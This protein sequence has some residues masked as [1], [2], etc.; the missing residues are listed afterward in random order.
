MSQGEPYETDGIE[1]TDSLRPDRELPRGPLTDEGRLIL[2]ALAREIATFEKGSLISSE[3]PSL[4]VSL[5]WECEKGHRW[6]RSLK[7]VRGKR[8]WCPVCRAN[9]VAP[10]QLEELARLKAHAKNRGGRCISESYLGSKIPLKWVCEKGH[11]FSDHANKIWNRARGNAFCPECGKKRRGNRTD[12]NLGH[13]Q[14]FAASQGGRC[15]ASEYQNARQEVEWEC[16]NKHRFWKSTNR[17]LH[18]KDWCAICGGNAPVDIEWFREYAIERGGI[19]LSDSLENI[20]SIIQ[21]RCARNHEWR[22]TAASVRHFKTW[23][24]R[25]APNAKATRDDA[26]QIARYFGGRCLGQ[27]RSKDGGTQWIWECAQKHR[28]T[29]RYSVV[30]RGHWCGDC[31]AY[32]G[33]R[34]CRAHMEAI[35]ET[36]FP[37]CRPSWL[38]GDRGVPL[39]LDGFS[40]DLLVAFEHQGR[41]HYREVGHFNGVLADLQRRDRLKAEI[42]KERGV[43]LALIPEIGRMTSLEDLPSL[44]ESEFVR[45]GIR[46]PVK[47]TEAIVDLAAVY[48]TPEEVRLFDELASL[49]DDMGGKLISSRWLG[50]D[51]KHVVRCEKGHEFGARMGSLRKGMW[52]SHED[53]KATRRKLSM[54]DT[55]R[56]NLER[57]Q[58]AAVNHGGRCLSEEFFGWEAHHEFACGHCGYR[59]KANAGNL[60]WKGTWCPKCGV[61]KM[62]KSRASP[63]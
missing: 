20:K 12:L 19:C 21:F 5:V 4:G 46:P 40:E 26:D 47:A 51:A 13:L 53:C 36:Q 48:A 60:V 61:S 42:C 25:C 10:D 63:K 30:K 33:E 58:R 31:S 57:V 14:K 32:L 7:S 37:R 50:A 27:T 6:E 17:V 9:G 23:C 24:G 1:M 38:V 52:C 11:S 15:L 18:Q 2:L 43:R 62:L 56:S 39:E 16:K 3:V 34:I 54:A 59:W 41:Q 29:Q 49:V 55:A 22:A 45:L 35:F 8:R 28:W 44:L